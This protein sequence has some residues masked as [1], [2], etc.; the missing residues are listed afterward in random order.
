MRRHGDKMADAT[1]VTVG[2]DIS[3]TYSSLCFVDGDE[4]VLEEGRVRTTKAG[5][6]RRFSTARCRVVLEVG[7]HSPWV[8]R[9]LAELGHEVIVANPRKVRLIA[10]SDRKHDRADAEQLARLLGRCIARD[11]VT[12]K[13]NAVIC[14]RVVN[15]PFGS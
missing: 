15:G 14:F 2:L 6:T 1:R 11:D 13:V 4:Q 3:D 12:V 7:T 5:L 10:E 9:L 8:S